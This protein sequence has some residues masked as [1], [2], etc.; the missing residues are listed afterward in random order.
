MQF[1]MALHKRQ[2]EIYSSPHRF[3]LVSIGRRFGKTRGAI[4]AAL[5]GAINQKGNI[6]YAAPTKNLYLKPFSRVIDQYFSPI[7]TNSNLGEYHRF[8][9]GGQIHLGGLLDPNLGRGKS[10]DRIFA[11]EAAHD[12]IVGNLQE[13]IEQ[14]I[15]PTMLERPT[16]QLWVMS[17]P[18]GDSNYFAELYRKAE[19]E[20]DGWKLWL[21][22]THDNPF[23]PP[24]EIERM[25][26]RLPYKVARQ[27]IFGELVSWNEDTFFKREWLRV[28]P[29]ADNYASIFVVA[30]TA[31]K[32]GNKHD[33]SG[34]IVFGLRGYNGGVKLIREGLDVLDWGLLNIDG[35]LLDGAFTELMQKWAVMPNFLALFIEDKASGSILYQQLVKKFTA[36]KIKRLPSKLSSISKADRAFRAVEFIGGQDV[37]QRKVC[38]TTHAHEKQTEFKG[39]L[40]NHFYDQV[41]NFTTER[42]NQPDDLVDCLT[43]GTIISME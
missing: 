11:D 22:S 32:G 34:Y 27:E 29:T 42:Y 20:E 16:S 6:L 37:S 38:I 36:N 3:N 18:K 28:V 2:R 8:R 5:D 19:A 21:G 35:D 9:S 31:V 23:I 40:K 13:W 41:L 25:I 1:S 30:D 26:G 12:K 15:M 7:L 43:Y 4:A 17:T 14:S 39:K 10:L 33:G 24:K